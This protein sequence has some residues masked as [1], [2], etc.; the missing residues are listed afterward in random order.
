MI[1]ID[2]TENEI[3]ELR[4]LITELYAYYDDDK[5]WSF[6]DLDN[7]RE[8]ALEMAKILD[9]KILEKQINEEQI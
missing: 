8:I 6:E 7:Q 9:D 1:Q 3:A 4:N 2:F 5:E